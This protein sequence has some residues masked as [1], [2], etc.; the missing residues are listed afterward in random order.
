MTVVA[1]PYNTWASRRPV[2]GKP[3]RVRRENEV[4]ALQR[5]AAGKTDTIAKHPK[6]N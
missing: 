5:W 6:L 2:A 4:A 1:Q 3:K